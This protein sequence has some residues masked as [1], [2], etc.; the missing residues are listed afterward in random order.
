MH[1]LHPP[2]AAQPLQQRCSHPQ[3]CLRFQVTIHKKS[4]ESAL[5]TLSKIVLPVKILNSDQENFLTIYAMQLGF[6][7]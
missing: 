1:P 3:K 6:L 5:K 7:N 2:Y 4:G